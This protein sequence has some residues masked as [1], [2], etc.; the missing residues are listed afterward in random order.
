MRLH[1]NYPSEI[2]AAIDRGEDIR[3]TVCRHKEQRQY[4]VTSQ[5]VGNG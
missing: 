4:A 5:Q 1:S 2:I 3:A